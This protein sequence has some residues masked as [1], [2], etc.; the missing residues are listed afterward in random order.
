MPN[1][2][3]EM[4]EQFLKLQTAMHGESSVEV[5]KVLGRIANVYF[6]KREYAKAEGLFN[7]ALTIAEAQPKPSQTIIREFRN[8]LRH[9]EQEQRNQQSRLDDSEWLKV[10]TDRIP[11]FNAENGLMPS[12]S[13]TSAAK[14]ANPKGGVSNKVIAD[15]KLHIHKLQQLAGHESLQVADAMTKL[16]DLYCRREELDEMEPLLIE[17][18]RMRE[19]LCGE[20]H[21]SVSTDLKNLGRLYYFKQKYDQAEALLQKARVIREGALGPTHSYVAD[22]AE[23]QARIMRKTHRIDEAL[24]LEKFVSDCRE[25]NV[26]DWEQLKTLGSQLQEA[27]KL[28]E[29][30]AMWLA[31]LDECSEFRFDDPRLSLTLEN[32]AEIYWRRRK[33]DKAEPLCKQILQIAESLLGPEHS[34]VGLAANNLAI[35]CERQG[36]HSDA[37]ILYQQALTIAENI[38][39]NSHPDTEILRESHARARFQALKQVEQK[40]EESHKGSRWSKSGW[41]KAYQQ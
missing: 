18:L 25:Q 20:N 38:L 29:A 39:G 22:V 8:K 31:A 41:W 33:Y 30:Q 14:E 16:A 5:A 32:L 2:S 1:E 6:G 35:L 28:L 19:K 21:L 26:S 40:L 3:L 4:L 36:K 9:I 27:G 23:W 12:A 7:D 37:A 13:A 17:A 24:K 10:S 15:A 34:D 11:V